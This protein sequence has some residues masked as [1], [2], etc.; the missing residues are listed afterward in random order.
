MISIITELPVN[1]NVF[2]WGKESFF[3]SIMV[4]P[5]FF[6]GVIGD[7]GKTEKHHAR[8]YYGSKRWCY[9][10]LVVMSFVH[11]VIQDKK[12]TSWLGPT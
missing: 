6:D 12:C 4:G 1:R 5:R 11:R 10:I 3:V 9:V 2:F 8:P 7:I